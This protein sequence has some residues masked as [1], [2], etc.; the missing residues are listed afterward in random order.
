MIYIDEIEI[1]LVGYFAEEME[2]ITQG[3]QPRFYYIQLDL[4]F[5]KIKNWHLTFKLS[6]RLT[7]LRI[8]QIYSTVQ[9]VFKGQKILNT[10]CGVLN[11]SKKRMKNEMIWPTGLSTR[12]ILFPVF[13]RDFLTFST[14]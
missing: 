6:I 3:L 13:F 2:I 5:L 11:S 14:I 8:N 10:S 4:V 1:R 7:F 12:V 9:L